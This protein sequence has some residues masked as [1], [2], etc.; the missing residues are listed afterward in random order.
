MRKRSDEGEMRS[1]YAR[2]DFPTLERG[3]Y[4]EKVKERSNVVVLDP[5]LSRIFKNSEAV[6]QAL[7]SLVEAAK[8][9]PVAE[10][11]SLML[12]R[13]RRVEG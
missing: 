6:N 9:V 5:A 13:G 12:P 2:E 7:K 11:E 1:S 4:H 10:T 8:A 3:K